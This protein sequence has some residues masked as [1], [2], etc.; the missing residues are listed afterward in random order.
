MKREEAETVT[1]LV[2]HDDRVPLNTRQSKL[3]VLVTQ[4]LLI[5]MLCGVDCLYGWFVNT[6]AG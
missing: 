1:P 5:L 6:D 2:A 4:W 3:P